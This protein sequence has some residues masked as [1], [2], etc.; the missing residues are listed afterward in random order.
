MAADFCT[1]GANRTRVASAFVS[2]RST[3]P[4]LVGTSTRPIDVPCGASEAYE[5]VPAAVPVIRRVRPVDIGSRKPVR[6]QVQRVAVGNLRQDLAAGLPG[7]PPGLVDD[8]QGRRREEEVEHERGQAQG[9]AERQIE[10]A[11]QVLAERRGRERDVVLAGELHRSRGGVREARLA[12][13]VAE[14]DEAVAR[15]FG[16]LLSQQSIRTPTRLLP[17]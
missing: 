15:S 13:D 14:L 12:A 3:S 6:H 7:D 11:Q 2:T 10:I 9:P 8:L 17:S 16:W 5:Y 4:A 1:P